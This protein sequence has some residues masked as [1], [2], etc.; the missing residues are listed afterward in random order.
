[1]DEISVAQMELVN[2]CPLLAGY[3]ED[4]VKSGARLLYRTF[5]N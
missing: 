5:I 4:D 1:M 3:C 2:L